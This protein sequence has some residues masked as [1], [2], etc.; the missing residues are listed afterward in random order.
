MANASITIKMQDFNQL[1]V[2]I[3]INMH[4]MMYTI[5]KKCVRVVGSTA[6]LYK[7]P[8]PLVQYT[9]HDI[10]EADIICVININFDDT[11][12]R[13][14]ARNPPTFFLFHKH[15]IYCINNQQVGT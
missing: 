5:A 10:T 11:A 8:H 1:S 9:V 6:L 14:G 4:F 13:T 2:C 7:I 15:H 12:T 3:I